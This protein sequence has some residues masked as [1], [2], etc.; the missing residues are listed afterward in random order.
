MSM[1]GAMDNEDHSYLEVMD[2]LAQHGA[3]PSR[4]REIL[5]R[6][7]VF[8]ILISNT[9]DHLRNHGFLYVTGKGWELSPAYDLN[10]TPEEIHPRVLRTK[11]D[12]DD[13]TA[14]LDLAFAVAEEFGLKTKKAKEIAREVGVAVSQ[15]RGIAQSLGI[16][17]SE[18]E[19]MR[20]AFEHRD[21]R[22]AASL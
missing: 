3:F 9:D 5:W 12:Y 21:L 2:A 20:S 11:I 18:I 10:P 4:D 8:S 13:A 22:Q 19:R 1:I 14:S 17:A 7:I 15:W 16:S 6:R